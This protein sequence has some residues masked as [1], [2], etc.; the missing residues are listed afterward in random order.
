MNNQEINIL[1][2]KTKNFTLKSASNKKTRCKKGTKKYKPLGQGC[3]TKY[4]IDNYHTFA[5]LTKKYGFKAPKQKSKS[6]KITPE[7]IIDETSP[8]LYLSLSSPTPTPTPTPKSLIP[9][10]KS[11]IPSPKAFIK[12]K[13]CK[14]GTRKYQPIGP[15]CYTKNEIDNYHTFAKLT[16]KFAFKPPK[17][18]KQKTQKKHSPKMVEV[19]EPELKMANPE[20][21]IVERKIIKKKRHLNIPVELEI[22]EEIPKRYNEEFIELMEKLSNIMHKKGEPFRAKAYQ[23][24]QETIMSYPADITSPE[25]LKGQSRIGPTIMDKLNEYVLTGT[26]RVLERE[27]T[28]PTNILSDIYGVGPK[29]A[30][31]L[32]NAG[33]KSIDELRERQ[34]KLL[35][36]VQKVG[37][38]YYEQ[39]QERIPRSEIEEFEEIFNV[40]FVKASQGTSDSKFEIVGSYRRG[41]KTSGDIDV[42]I[43]GNTGTVYNNF[44]D[45]LLTNG[46][47]LEVLSRGPSKTLV[48]A[49]LP[50]VSENGE[51]RIARRVDFLYAPPEEFAFAILYFTGSKIFNTVMRQYG[52]NA[53]YTFNE[54]GIY[55]LENKKKGSK[56][57]K[58]FKT[59]KD[60]F[61]F[62]GLEY[63]TPIERKDGRAVK[64][65]EAR[66]ELV[67]EAKEE[68]VQ[69]AKE[70]LVQEEFEEVQEPKEQFE[71][72]FEEIEIKPA[73]K[74]KTLKKKI[75]VSE[76]EPNIIEEININSAESSILP[77]IEKFK[78]NGIF[79]LEEL[80]EKQLTDIIRVANTKYYNQT[81]VMTDN[82]YDIVKEYIE[83]KYPDNVGITE[84]GADV[85]RNKVKLPYEMA[86]MEKI[87]PNTTALSTWTS[88]Y[89]GPYVISYKL[90]GVSGLYTTQGDKPKLYTRGNGKFGQDVSRLIP[91]LRLPKTK[92]I[93]IRGEFIISKS[94]FDEKYKTTAANP[95]NMV[96]G[97]VNRLQISD[98]I[99]DLHFVAYE[100]IVPEL[101]PSAQMEYLGTINVER[102]SYRTTND[103]SN[104]MLSDLLV[105]ARNKYMYEIDGIIVTDDK[106]YPRQSGNPEHSF[107]FKMVLTDQIAEAK[108]IDVLWNPSKDGYLKPR[109]QFEPIKLGGVTIQ[110]A[111]GFNGSFIKDNNIGIGTIV[112]IIRSGDVIPYIKSITVPSDEPKMPSVPYKWNETHVD[113]MLE[114]IVDDPTVKEKNITKFFR[115]IEVDSLSSGNIT[116][117]IKAGY[118]TV[119]KII[120]MTERDF[121]N[122]EGFKEKLAKKIYDGIK[123]KLKDAS[124]I[125]VMAASNIFGRGFSEKKLELVINDLPDIIV[126]NDTKE[127]KIQSVAS[128]KG[129]AIKTADS[130]VDKIDDFKE[131]LTECGLD[132]KLQENVEKQTFNETHP[133]FGKTVI[134]TG[135]RD[136]EIVEFLKNVGAKL[137]SN[138]SKNTFLVVA[139]TSDDDTGKAE[140]ARKLGVPLMSISEFKEKYLNK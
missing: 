114:N 113:I 104:E 71:E 80:N 59:E 60:I 79:V 66:E 90:D 105:D 73:K 57:N 18:V 45:Y 101:K 1:K 25:Q 12:M 125:K 115:D 96:A 85:A 61:D 40:A 39:I 112:E 20:L 94:V 3:Y 26:L 43:T 127:H 15:D 33:I 52:L 134:L 107:A 31:E 70:E 2:K 118:D 64:V 92:G 82:Q 98:A 19:V 86:S 7:L 67:Q 5:K 16:K 131:F 138:V 51:E 119:P 76:K 4:E 55:K 120:T 87:K 109:V 139:I 41:A 58:V 93:V 13:R 123:Q 49:R 116:R 137:G 83:K 84:I 69:E 38:K 122:V 14:K 6:K 44:I 102:V 135:H 88:T 36:D 89:R 35:N 11:L 126:S 117:I 103:L 68:L 65:K 42:I 50:G 111:T 97:M 47:I 136:K 133:L 37:L 129:M 34:D 8:T 106:I 130:F 23:K 132:Y 91:F 81:P 54:H 32:V 62:L 74:R 128:V 77:V 27:K 21:K 53:G 78:H 110:F 100:V 72:E 56:I 9:S 99:S 28:D 63:K 10:P 46:I 29:K 22:M 75:K 24:A 140:D 48:I 121:L 108:V 95:R 124:L 17:P 30:K